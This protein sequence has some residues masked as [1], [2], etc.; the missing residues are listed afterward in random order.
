MKNL[1]IGLFVLGLTSLG[2]SQNVNGEVEEV[3]LKDIVVANVN[4]GYLEKVQDKTMS[5]HVKLLEQ[6]AS[7]FNVSSLPEFDGRKESFKT[8]FRASKGYIIATYNHNGMILKTRERYSD[9]KLPK[10]LIKS[11]LSQYPNSDFL[12]VVYTV[13]YN[14]QKDVKKTYKIQIMKDNLIKNLKISSGGNIDKTVTMS[15]VN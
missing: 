14:H 8:I 13:N 6:K 15:I 11:V 1:V 9:I 4:L 3:K 5:D 7:T 2:F 10:Q 12:K